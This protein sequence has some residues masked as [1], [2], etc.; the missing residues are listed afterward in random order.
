M[1]VDPA[2][3]PGLLLLLAELMALAA[4]GYV[5]ARAVLRQSDERMALAQ[6]LVIGLALW[7]FIVNVVLHVIP[8]PAGVIAAWVLTLGLGAAFAWR[9]REPLRPAMRTTLGFV[10]AVLGTFWVALACRQMLSLADWQLHLGLATSIQVG[11][12]PPV[13]P[14]QP[15][16]PA[17]YHYGFDMLVGLLAPPV[18]PDLAFVTELLG[19]YV[20]MS[21]ALV[22]LTLLLHRGAWLVMLA[23]APLLLTTGSST[24]GNV[25]ATSDILRIPIPTEAPGPAMTD[26][27]GEIYWPASQFPWA[28][29]HLVPPANISWPSFPLSYA[30]AVIVLERSAD[31]SRRRSWRAA[32]TLAALLGF[33]GLVSEVVALVVLVL[34][35]L[36]EAVPALRDVRRHT[37]RPHRVLRAVAGPLLGAVLL[38]VSGGV[39][40]SFLTG[41]SGGGLSLEWP[42]SLVRGQPLGE[43]RE[44]VGAVRQLGLGPLA[45]AAV[46]AVVAWRDRLPLAL[47]AASGIFV[48]AALTLHYEFSPIDLTRMSGHARNFALLGLL[49]ALSSRLPTWRPRWRYAAAALVFALVTW[50]TA[51]A[52]AHGVGVALGRGPHFANAELGLP[53]FHE[54]FLGR[55][56]LGRFTTE[57]FMTEPVA[58]YVRTHTEAKAR[59]LSPSPGLMTVVTGRPNASGSAS[60]P[61]LLPF[62]GP[63]Y[64]DAIRVLDPAAIRRLGFDYVHATDEWLTTL[65]PRAVRRLQDPALFEPLIRNGPDALYRVRPAFAQL[66]ADPESFEVL[67]L[68]T[69]PSATVYL[70]PTLDPKDA[71][72]AA[73]A[74]SHAQLYGA[75]GWTRLHPR[76]I[77]VRPAPLGGRTPD[78]VVTSTRLA[79]SFFSS[80]AQRV[81]VWDNGEIAV[82]AP[83]GAIGPIAPAR[84]PTFSVRISG[85]R[86]DDG[87]ITFTAS[88]ADRA[89]ERW[90]SQDWQVVPMDTRAPW[91][92]PQLFHHDGRQSEGSQWYRGQVIAGFGLASFV[93]EF[94]ARA[95]RLRTQGADGR[96]AT[97][98]AS[99]R[100]LAPG[101]WL[102]AVRLRY[103]SSDI[104]WH[105]VA[106]IPVV[107]IDVADAGEVSYTAYEGA[108]SVRLPSSAARRP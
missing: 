39:V 75:V 90:S 64:S 94:D 100:W 42:D 76:R 73:S 3:I 32:L 59:I 15:G 11:G 57:R 88:F 80:P 62:R 26:S 87:R 19:A 25:E 46:A 35:A 84:T 38:A 106:L 48:L 63:A 6:G 102:L 7:G 22:V 68:A 77:P 4:V 9:A 54:W 56:A 8:A 33:L 92:L 71:A 34:W 104:D 66:E 17:P 79:P 67:R 12:F 65:P 103:A 53:E 105:D 89:P 27:L 58:D 86:V 97:V 70:S 96:F 30:L 47:V 1:T 99:E 24:L 81:P 49:A 29:R 85:V 108:L 14:W 83:G 72:R 69:P 82:Y 13:L 91:A 52:P 51:I 43:L 95:S 23:L 78:L 5:V 93:Y 20:W 16:M 101:T 31:S 44:G 107:R 28:T 10:V 55:F 37:A 74:L 98:K 41:A 36:L 60:F 21:L 61:H 45:V 2:V 50:P 40:A 18:G